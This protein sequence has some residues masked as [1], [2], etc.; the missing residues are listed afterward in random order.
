MILTIP[1][2]FKPIFSKVFLGGRGGLQMF[3]IIQASLTSFVWAST[4]KIKNCAEHRMRTYEN[5]PLLRNLK[6]EISYTRIKKDTQL[7]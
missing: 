5:P 1:P 3:P 2:L 6:A 7:R 4:R